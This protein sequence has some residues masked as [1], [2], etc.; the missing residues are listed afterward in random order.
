[1]LFLHL[2]RPSGRFQTGSVSPLRFCVY[3]CPSYKLHDQPHWRY[4]VACLNCK[5]PPLPHFIHPLYVQ[6]FSRCFCSHNLRLKHGIIIVWYIITFQF[7]C[8]DWLCSQCEACIMEN[9]S[10]SVLHGS[11]VNATWRVFSL[12]IEEMAFRYLEMVQIYWKTIAKSR[13]G[14]ILTL[15]VLYGAKNPLH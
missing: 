5:V 12:S 15:G 1:M 7:C 4:G 13:Q 2:I 3:V 14:V 6:I 9:S 8:Y 10:V 11:L